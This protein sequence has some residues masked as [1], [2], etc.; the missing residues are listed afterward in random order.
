MLYLS[1]SFSFSFS[2]SPFF[3]YV[4]IYHIYARARS[5]TRGKKRRRRHQRRSA[6]S[7]LKC[8]T[9]KPPAAKQRDTLSHSFPLLVSSSR[10]V[11]SPSL[12][13]RALL[14]SPR[15]LWHPPSPRCTRWAAR[16]GKCRR[17]VGRTLLPR[18]LQ[19][20]RKELER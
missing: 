19:G 14:T 9:A 20:D 4:S 17:E 3:L 8:E 11:L 6:S 10:V 13:V 12:S 16:E 2:S 5:L 18:S 15:T 1:T 7:L